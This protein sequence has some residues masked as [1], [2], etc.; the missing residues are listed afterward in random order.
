M[1]RLA[2]G[3]LRQLVREP[4]VKGKSSLT[5]GHSVILLWSFG[6]ALKL[7]WPTKRSSTTKKSAVW[8]AASLVHFYLVLVLCF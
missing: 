2:T 8:M 5:P 6:A 3:C 7:T 1:S 4:Q